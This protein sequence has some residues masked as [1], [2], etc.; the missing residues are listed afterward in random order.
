M[1]VKWNRDVS[2]GGDCGLGALFYAD[3]ESIHFNPSNVQLFIKS[4]L[5]QG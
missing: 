3:E 1:N 4:K 2:N 5:N